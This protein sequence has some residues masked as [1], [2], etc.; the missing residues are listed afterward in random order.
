MSCSRRCQLWEASSETA[1]PS[2]WEPSHVALACSL[3]VPAPTLD[4]AS[5]ASV[6][7][8]LAAAVAVLAA[9]VAVLAA[10]VLAAAVA[11]LGA[12]VLAAAVF[13]AALGQLAAACPLAAE[14]LPVTLHVA[15]AVP[16]ICQ[17]AKGNGLAPQADSWQ[18]WR[19]SPGLGLQP[20][21]HM[22][23]WDCQTQIA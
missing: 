11:V 21:L 23:E 14:L 8:V 17:Q 10:A 18:L 4:A 3:T 13:A 15:F 12:A 2:S 16:E 19:H 6:A 20:Q 9:A 1:L 5:A 7:A 22:V